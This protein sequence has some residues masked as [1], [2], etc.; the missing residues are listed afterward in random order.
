MLGNVVG[1]LTFGVISNFLG[2]SRSFL[3]VGAGVLV[4]AL[5][6]LLKIKKGETV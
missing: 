3:V 1:I 5:W 6:N 4:F 2:M